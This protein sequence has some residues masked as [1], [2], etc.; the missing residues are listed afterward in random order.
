MLTA[1]TKMGEC[2]CLGLDYKKDTLLE[3]RSKEEFF[4]PICGESVLLKLGDQ[5]IFH[6]AHKQSGVCRDFYEN[7]S[8]YHMEGKRQ[9][10]Q[11]LVEQKVPSILEYYDKEIQQRPDIMFKFNGEKFALEYQCSTIPESILIKRT[12][13]YLQNGYHPIWIISSNQIRTKRNNMVALSNFQYLFLRTTAA[14]KFYIPSYCP[15][16]QQFHFIGSI[17]PYSTR[18]AFAHHTFYPIRNMD[19]NDLLEPKINNQIDFSSWNNQ[20][21]KFLLNWTLHPSKQH[22]SFLH[23]IYNRN[24]NLFLLPTEIGLPI[25]HSLVIQTSP[26]IWQ[27]YLFIDCIVN[28]YVGDL[29]TLQEL[30][31]HFNKRIRRKEIVLRNLPQVTTGTSLSAILDYLLL[32]EQLGIITKMGETTFQLK[33]KIFIPR[34]NREKEEAKVLFFQKYQRFLSNR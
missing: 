27:T 9:L 12:N 16:K 29:I 34:T 31:F 7:E 5:R 10:Y 21:E 17:T 11:W 19:M 15:E 28:K 26:I 1:Q 3:L 23:E 14:G 33:R 32:L 30:S 2:I 13:S 25:P 18:N 8:I 22:H 24:L 4:C 20:I 6:F